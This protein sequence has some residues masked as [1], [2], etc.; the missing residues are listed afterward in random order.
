M[1]DR[2]ENNTMNERIDALREFLMSENYI[3]ELE[4][5]TYEVEDN[6]FNTSVGEFLVL[7][8]D[9]AEEKAREEIRQSLWAF[10]P[11]FILRHT[12]VYESTS[13]YEDEAIIEA[14]KEMQSR[15]CESANELVYALIDNFDEFCEDAIREDGRGNFLSWYDGEEYKSDNFYIYRR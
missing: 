11:D 3:E 4:E 12:R 2:K 6:C 9:E 15:I 14:L 1:N 10:N 7:T 5:L 8:D 13:I